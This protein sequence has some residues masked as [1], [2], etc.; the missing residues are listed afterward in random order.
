M[1]KKSFRRFLDE[2]HRGSINAEGV[3]LGAADTY[4]CYQ[5]VKSLADRL[6]GNPD[7]N[8]AHS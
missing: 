7:N 1:G 5:A 8:I 3:S 4:E 6:L 2:W